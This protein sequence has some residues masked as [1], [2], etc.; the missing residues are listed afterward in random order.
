M[1]IKEQ[2]ERFVPEN[3]QEQADKQYFLKWIE[4][5]DDILTRENAFAHFSSS[6]FVVNHNRS[7]MLVV[8]HNIFDG[9]IYPGGHADGEEDL[10]AVAIREVEEETGQKVTVLNNQ[11]FGIQ[12]NPTKGHIKRGKY[13]SSHT[14]LDVIYLLEAD[15]QTP[16]TYREDESKGVKWISLEEAT[17][18][19]IVDFARPV[20]KKLIK[21][22]ES[23]KK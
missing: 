6:A 15:D 11:I 7:K 13:I 9:W 17:D 2:I 8:Y 14:H 16:L 21:K 5:F 20:H 3:E 18:E 10:L 4:T 12:A 1:S 22:L 19:S 23:M